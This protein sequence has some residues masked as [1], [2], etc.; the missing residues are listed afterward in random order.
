MLLS[1]MLFACLVAGKQAKG[2]VNM[3]GAFCSELVKVAEV[4]QAFVVQ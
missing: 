4:Y 2:T 3:N 1:C